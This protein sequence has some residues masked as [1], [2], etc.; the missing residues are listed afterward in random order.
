M[1]FLLAALMA[2]VAL[3]PP[4]LAAPACAAPVAPGGAPLGDCATCGKHIYFGER[5]VSC[6]LAEKRSANSHPCADCAEPILIGERCASCALKKAEA[7]F[8]HPCADCGTTIHLGSLC[9]SCAAAHFKKKFAGAVA[10]AKTAGVALGK[11]AEKR[12]AALFDADDEAQAQEAAAIAKTEASWLARSKSWLE[13]R[14]EDGGKQVTAAA[15]ELDKHASIA[16]GAALEIASKVEGKKRDL[17]EAGFDKVLSLP[18]KSELGWVSLGDLAAAKMVANVPAMEGTD[19][20]DDP[21]AVLAALI[22][23]DPMTFLMDLELVPD[24]DGPLTIMDAFAAKSTSD[25]KTALA[26]LTL[27]EATRRLRRGE[28]ITRSLRDIS[29]SLE[30]LAPPE[31]AD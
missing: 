14:A 20:V 11:D 23:L 5:C 3:A 31:P 26:C 18:V 13:A 8:A 27:I 30:I 12:L 15:G 2:L 10:R 9:A 6:I 4:P 16:L 28:D 24:E 22:V 1:K 19:L 25:P 7:H 17:A 21:A 29:R